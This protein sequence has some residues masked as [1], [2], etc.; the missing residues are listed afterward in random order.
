MDETWIHHFTP[1]SN[2]Q[3]GKWAAAGENHPKTQTSADKVF[4]SVFWD[5]QDILFID[6]LEKGRNINSNYY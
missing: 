6:Y 4:V 5:A 3:S 1:K 2:R